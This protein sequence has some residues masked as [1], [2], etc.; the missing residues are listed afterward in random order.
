MRAFAAADERRAV[1]GDAVADRA[2]GEESMNG[3]VV[4]FFRV[5]AESAG[6]RFWW[7]V[8]L[9]VMLPLTES[10]GLAL[11]LPTLQADRKSV[12]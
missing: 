11:M 1:D 12:V 9:I 3:K 5:L 6:W 7:A 10:A 8:T 2:R 4:A